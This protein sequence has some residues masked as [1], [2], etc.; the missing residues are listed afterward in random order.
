[1]SASNANNIGQWRNQFQVVIAGSNG[2]VNQSLDTSSGYSQGIYLKDASIKAP[3][4]CNGNNTAL[5]QTIFSSGTPF[6]PKLCAAACSSLELCQFFNTYILYKNGTALGQNC[7]LY[8]ES[9][10]ST[11]SDST[12][13]W[14]GGYHYTVGASYAFSN[15]TNP[16]ICKKGTMSS[17]SPTS[18]HAPVTSSTAS[19][20]KAT[21][22]TR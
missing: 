16:G 5:Q 1:V 19:G 14:N 12:G 4:D 20:S 10:N 6:D 22:S 8:S 11:Y 7:A 2:Y 15:A 13:Y 17:S 9:W 21:T 18:S 3:V